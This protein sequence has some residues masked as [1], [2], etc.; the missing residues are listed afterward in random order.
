M[1]IFNLTKGNQ[2]SEL[3]LKIEILKKNEIKGKSNNTSDF[4]LKTE[5][6]KKIEILVEGFTVVDWW[7]WWKKIHLS[8]L[9]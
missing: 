7:N 2:T 5:I 6:Q 1:K 3:E 4:E 8:Y 9:G